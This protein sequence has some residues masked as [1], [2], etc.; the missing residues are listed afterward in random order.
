[1]EIWIV[2]LGLVWGGDANRPTSSNADL[3]KIER[4]EV[5][6]KA[7]CDAAVRQ[8]MAPAS[9]Y[10]TGRVVPVYRG[11]IV[12]PFGTCAGRKPTPDKAN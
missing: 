4:V 11:D 2:I 5:A 10:T 3:I 1:M 9:D 8:W 6:T 12:R 7:D